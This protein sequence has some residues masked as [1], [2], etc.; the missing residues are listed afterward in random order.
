MSSNELPG[1][2]IFFIRI[3]DINKCKRLRICRLGL[4]FG[5]SSGTPWLAGKGYD[6]GLVV[7]VSESALFIL[8]NPER[9]VH[10]ADAVAGLKSRNQIQSST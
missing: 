4:L 7:D 1:L 2:F 10:Y 5:C 3:S 6:H 8:D 9:N